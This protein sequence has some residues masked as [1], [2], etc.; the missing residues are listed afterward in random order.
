MA[1]YTNMDMNGYSYG[2]E[3]EANG[4]S[5]GSENEY[6][7]EEEYEREIRLL[8]EK[9][10]LLDEKKDKQKKEKEIMDALK[11][12]NELGVIKTFLSWVNNK[13]LNQK[14]EK[15]RFEDDDAGWT[16]IQKVEKKETEK[17]EKKKVEKTEM[18]RFGKDKCLHKNCRYAHSILELNIVDCDYGSNCK[19]IYFDQ[20]KNIY[21]NDKRKSK[22]CMRIH[23]KETKENFYSRVN[24]AVPVTKEEMDFTYD[25]IVDFENNNKK[26]LEDIQNKRKNI[27]CNKRITYDIPTPY[28]IV[29]AYEYGLL[30]AVKET[31]KEEKIIKKETKIIKKENKDEKSKNN[32]KIATLQTKIEEIEKRIKKNNCII[33]RFSARVDI[34]ICQQK[35]KSLQAENELLKNNLV[36]LKNDIEKIKNPP[37]VQETPKI[38]PKVEIKK[39]TIPEK[40]V[41]NKTNIVSAIFNVCVKS[42]KAALGVIS[43]EPSQFSVEPKVELK[44][45]VKENTKTIMCKSYGKYICPMGTNCRFAHSLKEL[46]IEKCVYGCRCFDVEFISGSYTNRK[47]SKNRVCNRIHPDETI[48]NVHKRIGI[49]EEVSKCKTELC[50]SV[51]K[52][53]CPIGINCRFAHNSKELKVLPCNFGLNCFDVEYCSGV[54]RNKKNMKNRICQ[55]Q[56]PEESSKNVYARLGFQQD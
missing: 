34:V 55:R 23:P 14:I 28:N 52:Y 24:I 17:V 11:L 54:Y 50:R 13:P 27:P 3:Y 38:Q 9:K 12:K 2:S 1:R 51:G 4:Y 21:M 6:D 47:N 35:S 10:R 45:E 32:Q 16:K 49:I 20:R 19:A 5:Y 44:V 53:T 31:K 43:K 18:C 40:K 56:H 36:N 7:S 37:K 26:F 22:I 29:R 42:F 8:E 33:E 39:E 15:L 46:K 41:E 25:Y 30:P 48:E